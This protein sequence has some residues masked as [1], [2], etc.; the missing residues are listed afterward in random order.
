MKESVVTELLKLRRS[1]SWAVVGFVPTAS[2]LS[3][4][5]FVKPESWQLLWIRSVG[6]YGMALLPVS[7]A[8][9]SSL[10]WRAEHQGSNWNALMS[11]PVRAWR[12]VVG[13][14][15]AIWLLA[16]VMQLVLVC[17]VIGAGILVLDLSGFFPVRY[18]MAGLLIAISCAPVCALQSA[19]SSM[20]RSFALPVAVGLVLTGIGTLLLLMRVPGVWILPRAF[21]TQAT[22]MGAVSGGAAISFAAQEITRTSVFFT[23]SI[24]TIIT[25]CLLAATSLILERTDARI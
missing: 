18:P 16:I 23:I 13:K 7:L 2:V 20:T 5:V 22:Q 15:A 19:L 25:F 1:T 21:A 14:G 9:L 6:F 10:V 17:S 3:A 24:S 11:A 8:V 12:I 4:C